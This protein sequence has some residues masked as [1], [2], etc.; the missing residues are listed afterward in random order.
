MERTPL[1]LTG[2][3]KFNL[4]S[5]NSVKIKAID[6]DCESI[7]FALRKPKYKGGVLLRGLHEISP[8]LTF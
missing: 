1:Q 5:I 6:A 3:K 2:W 8:L 4:V 7:T